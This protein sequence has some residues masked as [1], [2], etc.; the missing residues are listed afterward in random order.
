MVRESAQ[1]VEKWEWRGGSAQRASI[2]GNG[3]SDKKALHEGRGCD[4]NDAALEHYERVSSQDCSD[5]ATTPEVGSGNLLGRTS[6]R[7]ESEH[8]LSGWCF[9]CMFEAGVCSASSD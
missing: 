9:A 4:T 3:I 2:E 8:V 5:R 1:V 7:R 6:H